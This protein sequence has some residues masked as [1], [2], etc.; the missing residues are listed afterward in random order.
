MAESNEKFQVAIDPFY[1]EDLRQMERAVNYRRWQFEMVEP[2]LQGRVL[3][4]GGGI[5]NF[6]SQLAGSARSVVT[7][8]P[9]ESCFKELQE[10]TRELQNVRAVRATVETLDEVLRTEERFDCIV[11]MN[12]LEHIE[13]DRAVLLELKSRLAVGGR[14][15]ILVPAGPWAYGKLDERLGHYRR[16]SK[17]SSTR[18][19][20]AAELRVESMR[21]YNFVGLWGWWWNAK[22]G[23]LE[24]QSDA[25]IRFF[26]HWVVPFMS[27]IERLICPPLGQSILIVGQNFGS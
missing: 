3:E 10:K 13:D 19:F 6:T 2:F 26:D 9:N 17:S 11:M 1:A 5:G 20:A 7:V 25:Q 16:Y 23:K 4:V 18:L 8:E 22:M 12:V 24:G 14:V 21:Y 27:R 15:I